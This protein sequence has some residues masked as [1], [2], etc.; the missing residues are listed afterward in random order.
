MCYHVPM[1]RTDDTTEWMTQARRGLIEL[2]ILTLVGQAARYGSTRHDPCSLAAVGGEQGT[3]YPL[4]RRLEKEQV[5][6]AQWQESAA[7]PPRKYY[8]LTA[9]GDQR[10]DA[11]AV[12]WIQLTQAVTE[13]QS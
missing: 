6:S 7:G 10:R 12:E 1:S 4:L 11:L 8:T 2:C 9:A 5:I 13:L 3:L